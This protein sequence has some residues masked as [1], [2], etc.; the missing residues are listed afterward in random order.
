[1]RL[2]RRDRD[3]S[4]PGFSGDEGPHPYVQRRIAGMGAGEDFLREPVGSRETHEPLH[5]SQRGFFCRAF[6]DW[7]AVPGYSADDLIERAVVVELP[8]E[9]GDVLGRP[10]LQQKAAFVVVQ[11]ESHDV[12]EG[13]VQVHADGVA[14]EASPVGEL[15]G[16]DDDVAQVNI[17]ED[18]RHGR[19][20]TL[21]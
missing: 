16:F 21:H 15:V 2:L 13:F 17:P 6:C 20:S 11:A 12:A 9:R 4:H 5:T 10:A 19:D 18:L 7:N 14:A 3:V 1:M 8:P